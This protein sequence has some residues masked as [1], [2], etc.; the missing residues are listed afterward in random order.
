METTRKKIIIVDDNIMNLTAAR[1]ALVRKYDIFTVT[2]GKKLFYLMEQVTPDLILLDIEMPDMDGYEIIKILKSNGKSSGVP[3][4]FL[5]SV[6][7]PESELK[8]LS[9]GAID[10]IT[11]PFSREL[12]LKRIEVHLF[13][14][15]QKKRLEIYSNNLEEVVEEKRKTIF[16]L[17]NT[18]LRTVAELV[19][20]RDNVTGGHIERTQN[21]L[22]FLVDT[23]VKHDVYAEELST[24]DVGLFI[25][26][27]QLHD[28]G[29]ISIKDNILLK[30]AR[31]TIDEFSEMKR[32]TAF[33][34]NIIKKIEEGTRENTF[35]RHA[36][37]LAGSH[38]E[39]WDGSGYLLGLRGDAIPLQGR[40][41]AIVDVYDALTNTR[42]YKKAFSHEDALHIIE[43]G[44][45]KHFDP[46]IGKIFLEHE[47][48]LKQIAGQ[49]N[50]N[51]YYD[52]VMDLG[53]L[54][55]SVLDTVANIVD[56]RGGAESGPSSRIPHYLK[57]FI[58]AL[59]DHDRYKSEAA[60]WDIDIVLLS[61]QL[62][63]VGKIS[64]NDTILKKTEQLTSEE[65]EEIKAHTDIGVKVVNEIKGKIFEGDLFRHAEALVGSHHEKW[66]GTGYPLG[67]KGE[68]IPLQGRIMA[69][70]DVY[71]ALTSDRPQRK[72]ISHEE[73]V[74]IIKS[75]GGTYFDPELVNV[76]A[77]HSAA[78]LKD[79]GQ[80]LF[81]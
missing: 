41:M 57:I 63:D 80:E 18:I 75:Y 74:D 9:L 2:S 21:Y 60:S 33:G 54:G 79:G 11:K 27:S 35:L 10:Y 39:K 32:H 24:W 7:D 62:H 69:I 1:N 37:I 58:D 53:D 31:L 59:L 40:L 71:D 19:E 30:P 8:G 51:F 52:N 72:K 50:H 48:E 45:G 13:V 15:A 64:I 25:M 36:R 14:E 68:A 38:H 78:F 26:S 66:D 23:L 6:I 76:F 47:K 67:L 34:M 29:K 70:V 77:A 73:A 17:Q 4:I 81:K 16:E 65:Y 12:L 46:M 44:V 20:S 55:S 56:T 49:E 5:T 42:P 3:V 22:K 28:V 61:A 43:D